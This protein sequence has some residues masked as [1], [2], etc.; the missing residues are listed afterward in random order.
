MESVKKKKKLKNICWEWYRLEDG[1]TRPAVVYN[2]TQ[3]KTTDIK[4]VADMKDH[5]RY[6]YFVHLR[7]SKK[8]P[9]TVFSCP[10][11]K[12]QST[13]QVMPGNLTVVNV[14][15]T[16]L[17]VCWQPIP[18]RQ[19]RGFLTHYLLC[20]SGDCENITENQTC[21]TFQHLSP[22]TEY[23]ISVAGATVQGLGPPATETIWTSEDPTTTTTGTVKKWI[24]IMV[25]LFCLCLMAACPLLCMRLRK[26]LPAV[27]K[28]VIV[29]VKYTPT[30]QEVPA[31]K[32][33]VHVATLESMQNT[34]EVLRLKL[35]E[36]RLLLKED[37]DDGGEEPEEE[38]GED[39]EEEERGMGMDEEQ[40]ERM[41]EMNGCD[42]ISLNPNYKRQTLRIQELT[43]ETTEGSESD[44]ASP[45]YKNG[46]FFD[47][48][49]ELCENVGTSL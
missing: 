41:M 8:K 7:L 21:K 12:T 19:Q 20:L 10:T 32:E 34:P 47:V 40:D 29:S 33:E 30:S 27:P 26:K 24:I 46:L 25:C 48:K 2:D 43:D 16:S 6:Y 45:V 31:P 35:E 5:V 22:A 36:G 9:H 4:A 11:Y 18:V 42:C 17:Q 49:V 23:S 44:A 39:E 1:Q 37:G 28:P 13:P 3:R 15:S 14:S 38:R